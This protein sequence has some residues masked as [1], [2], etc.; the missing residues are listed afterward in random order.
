MIRDSQPAGSSIFVNFPAHWVVETGEGEAMIARQAKADIARWRKSQRE[1][2]IAARLAVPA[3]ER[4]RVAEEVAAVLDQL[5]APRSGQIISLYWPFRGELDLRNWMR[6]AHEKGARTALPVV[7]EKAQ[8]LVFREWS[9]G[10]RMERGVWNIPIPAS[11]TQI[12]PNIVIAPL[13]GHDPGC[14]RLGY[15][16]GF[17]DRTLAAMAERPKVIGVGLPIAELSTIFPQPFDIPMD[18]IVTGRDRILTRDL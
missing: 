18:V 6:T 17:Y 10:C 7:E 8:P 5:V 9:P 2:L 1:A 15:G 11:D 14:F 16:G 3:A 13:V 12:L 4:T